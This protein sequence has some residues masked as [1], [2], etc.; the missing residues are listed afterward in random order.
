MNSQQLQVVG[1]LKNVLKKRLEEK[2]LELVDLPIGKTDRNIIEYIK[3]AEENDFNDELGILKELVYELGLSQIKKV[4][5]P[6]K[7]IEQKEKKLEDYLAG[8]NLE[9]LESG[10]RFVSRQEKIQSGILDIVAE[11]AEKQLVLVELKADDYISEDVVGQL[12]KYMHEKDDGRAIF[13]A[14][15]IKPDLFFTLKPY[16]E[17][18]RLAF[19]EVDQV[20][21]KNYSFRKFSEDNLLT[22]DKRSVSFGKRTFSKSDLVTIVK[23]ERIAENLKSSDKDSFFSKLFQNPFYY[24]V[25]ILTRPNLKD[26]QRYL[27][28]IEVDENQFRYLEELVAPEEF[29]QTLNR[30]RNMI[31]YFIPS[32][33]GNELTSQGF[34]L[35]HTSN[36]K[37]HNQVRKGWEILRE[38]GSSVN[39]IIRAIYSSLIH[40]EVDEEFDIMNQTLISIG[41]ELKKIGLQFRNNSY[42]S[43]C[44]HLV[45]E[46]LVDST[47][48]DR[49]IN[50]H[51][52][53]VCLDSSEEITFSQFSFLKAD[54]S[55]ALNKIDP[56]L[57]RAY[58]KFHP[59]I[60]SLFQNDDKSI[61]KM[62]DWKNGKLTNVT[63]SPENA[64][65]YFE[66]DNDLYASI[67]SN[68]RV[69]PYPPF[70]GGE[71]ISLGSFHPVEQVISQPII[72]VPI[73]YEN[74][75]RAV[76]SNGHRDPLSHDSKLRMKYFVEDLKIQG[77]SDDYIKALEDSFTHFHLAKKLRKREA[78]PKDVQLR[79]FFDDINLDYIMVGKIPSAEELNS[80]YYKNC[81]T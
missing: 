63:M 59:G 58:L 81:V 1:T 12:M 43:L 52:L 16:F 42:I 32:Q 24:Q 30:F 25:L 61:K 73:P 35:I 78:I 11:S 39:L 15:K 74:L 20:G 7:K 38:K 26:K 29:V 23:A 17:A 65:K 57:A 10:L 76:Y 22:N 27:K 68:L 40:G 9:Q 19:F 28:P 6:R 2:V 66:L 64:I 49:K 50:M 37:E 31:K 71:K 36:K 56:E 60:F 70:Q 55:I 80:L 45:K 44:R 46:S 5:N 62:M 75:E 79:N 72:K 47:E 41:K 77:I 4:I 34:G 3:L 33:K 69:K 67:L 13:V 48:I 8:P 54:R 14:P 18:G 51:G 53:M 21:E